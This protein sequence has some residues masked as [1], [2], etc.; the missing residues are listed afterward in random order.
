[1]QTLDP[2]FTEADLDRLEALCERVAGFNPDINLEWLDGFMTTLLAGPRLMMPSEWLP[3][4]FGEDFGRVF[5]DPQDMDQAMQTLVV[6]WN[7]IACAL[8]PDRLM[9]DPQ[10]IS[11]EPLMMVI[12]DEFRASAVA[13]SGVDEQAAADFLQT[14]C[15][16]ALGFTAGIRAFGKD[17]APPVQADD[18]RWL[19]D[20]VEGVV[21]L[22]MPVSE[23][24]DYVARAYA[25]VE[26]PSRDQLLDDACFAVQDLRMFWLEQASRT[27]SR[28]VQPKPGRN[29]LCHCGSGRKYKKCHGASS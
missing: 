10:A 21:A 16:W 2:E 17:W 7:A 25:E 14:G 12:D 11:L 4:I 1:M 19:A 8:H 5:A 13:R 3:A 23:L 29:E 24:K 26:P 6:R 18:D 28:R 20:C 9:A 27:T 22:M 15:Q